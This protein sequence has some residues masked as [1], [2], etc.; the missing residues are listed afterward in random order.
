MKEDFVVRHG[1]GEGIVESALSTIT[2]LIDELTANAGISGQVGDGLV[3]GQ[4]LDTETESFAGPER[5]GRAVVGDGL[6]QSA[7]DGNRMAHVCFLLERLA[8]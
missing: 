2:L 1:G 4:S 8:M 5:F 7:D 3:S 6:V